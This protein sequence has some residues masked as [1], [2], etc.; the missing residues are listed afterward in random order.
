MA[1]N[2]K[3]NGILYGYPA[4]STISDVVARLALM[5]RRIEVRHNEQPVPTREF[6]AIVL[7]E[8]DSV[9]VAFPAG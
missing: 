3:V 6:A 9:D 1:V 7:A 5:S 2:I 4:G 8:N